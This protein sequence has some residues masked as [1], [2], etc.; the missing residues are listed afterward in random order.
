[1]A[2][3]RNPALAFI[4]TANLPFIR[5]AALPYHC[6]YGT[7]SPIYFLERRLR[8]HDHGKGWNFMKPKNDHDVES[9]SVKKKKKLHICVP[10]KST[11]PRPST[12]T[13]CSAIRGGTTSISHVDKDLATRGF[14]CH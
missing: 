10:L 5:V 6:H 11:W 7:I 4:A 3:A 12:V 13:T 14:P 8:K 9:L 2:C 1:M